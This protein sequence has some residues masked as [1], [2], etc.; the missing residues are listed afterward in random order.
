MFF[1]RGNV[2]AAGERFYERDVRERLSEIW[3]DH[4][5]AARRFSKNRT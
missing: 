5:R 3:R 1:S 4:V 2:T